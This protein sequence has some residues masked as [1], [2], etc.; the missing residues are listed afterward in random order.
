LCHERKPG[1][2]CFAGECGVTKEAAVAYLL[3]GIELQ[4]R[5]DLVDVKL[6]LGVLGA[7]RLGESIASAW[8]ARTGETPLI[9]SRSGPRRTKGETT[10]VTEWARTLEAESVVIAFPGKPLLNL[11]EDSER[12]KQFKGNIFSAAAS[13]S[14]ESLQRVFPQATIVCISPFLID[15]LHSIPMLI[16]RPSD[17]PLVQWQRAKGVLENFGDLDLVEDEESFA[18]LSLLG[19]SWPA[20]VLAAVEAAAGTGIQRLHNDAAGRIGRRLFFRAI[21]SLLATRSDNL[22]HEAA[23]EREASVEI[24][25]PGG[26]TER[27]LTSLGEVTGLFDSVFQQMQTRAEELRA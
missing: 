9:W 17:L 19:A 3:H 12:A 4:K 22:E 24:A 2:R 25:T 16:L 6:R 11:A 27:G 23:V 13:L 18:H 8:F 14:R 26:I 5:V 1:A 15:G 10:W 21:Q 7:G 20:V